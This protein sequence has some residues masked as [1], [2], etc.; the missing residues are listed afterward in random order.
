MLC[1]Y[2]TWTITAGL[3]PCL[4]AHSCLCVWVCVCLGVCVSVCVCV[5]MLKP[6][7]HYSVSACVVFCETWVLL[8]PAG[9]LIFHHVVCYTT[10]HCMKVYVYTLSGSLFLS[11]SIH[12]P[13][14]SSYSPTITT[15]HPLPHTHSHTRTPNQS[16]ELSR[17]ALEKTP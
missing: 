9:T 10:L 4:C 6:F 7:L 16:K 11:L 8:R 14:P 1:V 15:T 5:F 12:L 3:L 13:P 2:A 17:L